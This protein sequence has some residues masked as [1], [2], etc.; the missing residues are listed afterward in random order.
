MTVPAGRT[1]TFSL[2]IFGTEP[3]SVSRHGRRWN[4]RGRHRVDNVGRIGLRGDDRRAERRREWAGLNHSRRWTRIIGRG[5][6][7]HGPGEE[8]AGGEDGS[9]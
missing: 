3:L 2:S 8:R 4:H 7:R 6:R 5:V 9:R 1:L